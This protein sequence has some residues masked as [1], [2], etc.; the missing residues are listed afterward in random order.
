MSR[1]TLVVLAVLAVTALAGCSK[2]P[3]SGELAG[4][5]SG[6]ALQSGDVATNEYTPAEFPAGGIPVV[7]NDPRL[8]PPP[9]TPMAPQCVPASS[10]FD[11]HVMVLPTPDADGYKAFLVGPA[12]EL[13]VGIVEPDAA[14]MWRANHTFEGDLSGNY[15]TIEVRMGAFV[16]ATASA[17]EG[18]QPFALAEGLSTVTSSGSYKGK[19]LNVTV[20]N[21]PAAGSFV[22]RLYTCDEESKLLSVA[23]TFPVQ[24][25]SNEFTA[26]LN[27]AD[28]AEYHIHVGTSLINLYKMQIGEPSA[29]S[30]AAAPASS[31][32][33]SAS[34]MS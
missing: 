30:G 24:N 17:A 12:G 14:N 9:G 31:A 11:V 23:A 16:L 20:S 6:L 13:E 33:G 10:S 29:C 2:A 7:G 28:Y 21:L 32:T 19:E 1:V 3:P 8:C 26:T 25:G 27:I 18:A 34:A 4:G 22:G 5:A 15:T